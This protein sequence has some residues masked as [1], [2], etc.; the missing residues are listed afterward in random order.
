MRPKLHLA[1]TFVA[2]L[3]LSSLTKRVEQLLWVSPLTTRSSHRRAMDPNLGLADVAGATDGEAAIA[4]E[5]WRQRLQRASDLSRSVKGGNFVQIATVDKEGLP[6]CRTVVFRG[7][8]SGSRGEAMRMITDARSEKVTQ[9]QHSP[10]CEMVW[11]FGLSSEQFR[12]GGELQLVGAEGTAF[13]ASEE[14]QTARFEQWK[15]LSDAAREQF[16]WT[17]PGT[18]YS[19]SA[20][21]KA[22]DYKVGDPETG[23]PP[24]DN[25]LMMLL[26]PRE[27]KYLRLTDNFAQLDELDSSGGWTARRVNP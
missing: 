2:I 27:V 22:N 5:P 23:I 12:I 13:A 3:A 8:L 21:R 17:Q 11:W 14:L 10:A 7:F 25:F 4:V 16:W 15:K 9:V 1:A 6:H 24:P 20:S 26:W 19:L 18:D